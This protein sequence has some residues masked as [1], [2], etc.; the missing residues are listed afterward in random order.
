V[1]ID[2]EDKTQVSF[3]GEWADAT[4]RNRYGKDYLINASSETE[5]QSVI[6][7]QTSMFRE[8]TNIRLY[9]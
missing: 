4:A 9:S 2:N 5:G 7:S 6:F 1:L 3:T 8:N